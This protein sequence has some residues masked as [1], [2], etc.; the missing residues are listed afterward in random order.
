MAVAPCHSDPRGATGS[1]VGG[2]EVMGLTFGEDACALPRV[3]SQDPRAG[4]PPDPFVHG[5]PPQPSDVD[6]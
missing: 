3:V 2:E 6:A 1:A 4:P 5:V